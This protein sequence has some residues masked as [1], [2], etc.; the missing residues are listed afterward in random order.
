MNITIPNGCEAEVILPNG[1][2]EIVEGGIYNYECEIDKKI[3][4]HF[5]LINL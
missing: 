4:A 1:E 2:K 3:I 5:L